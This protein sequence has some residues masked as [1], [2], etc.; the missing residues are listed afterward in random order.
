MLGTVHIVD[1]DDSARNAI[2]RLL[3]LSG[4]R[5]C[6]YDAGQKLLDD[7]LD[8][9]E[10]ACILLDLRMLGL[11]GLDVL[12][13]LS[14][15]EHPPVIMVSAHGDVAACATAMKAGALDFLEKPVGAAQ[16]RCAVDKA[17]AEHAGVQARRRDTSEYRK[18]I[19]A[20]TP[21][22]QEVLR[23]LISG[24]LNKVIA[25]DLNIS[26]KTVKVHRARVLKKMQVRSVAELARICTLVDLDPAARAEPQRA[27]MRV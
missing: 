17:L 14:T 24:R 16:L 10:P 19:E 20:L 2:S 7:P 5:V 23:Y 15:R 21:R 11:S 1:D 27:G 3:S 25:S 22:E 12:E 26:E 9:V 6:V 18:L 8:S 4:Y 13:K